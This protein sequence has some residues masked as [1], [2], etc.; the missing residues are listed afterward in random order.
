LISATTTTLVVTVPT[1]G[2]FTVTTRP[3]AETVAHRHH[4]QPHSGGH[5]GQ[6]ADRR[7]GG[8]R[9]WT[10]RGRRRRLLG[11]RVLLRHRH[12]DCAVHAHVHHPLRVTALNLGALARGPSSVRK[13]ASPALRK[14]SA[15]SI[16]WSTLSPAA[17]SWCLIQSNPRRD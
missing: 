10:E 17:F 8:Y 4:H 7:G 3:P 16:A 15:N 14:T 6:R 9:Q 2:T 12:P 5:A 11:Q 13:G 1:V